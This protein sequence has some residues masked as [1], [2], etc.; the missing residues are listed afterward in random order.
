MGEVNPNSGY[1]SSEYSYAIADDDIIK[2]EEFVVENGDLVIVYINKGN[3]ALAFFS[4]CRN[5][6][7]MDIVLQSFKDKKIDVVIAGRD[8]ANEGFTRHIIDTLNPD[9]VVGRLNPN[10]KMPNNKIISV[11]SDDIFITKVKD[12]IVKL[13][14]VKDNP[15]E[16]E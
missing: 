6:A 5:E 2:D 4:G 8:Y 15:I 1:N 9:T 7:E 16:I 3:I 12:D 10:I 14:M 13:R 11:Q